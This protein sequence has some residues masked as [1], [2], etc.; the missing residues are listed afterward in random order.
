M[1]FVIKS[2]LIDTI[3]ETYALNQGPM[4]HLQVFFRKVHTYYHLS[5]TVMDIPP[6]EV[7]SDTASDEEVEDEHGEDSSAG[8]KE[9]P[10]PPLTIGAVLRELPKIKSGKET[11]HS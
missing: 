10:P 9:T 8:N 1:K 5:S 2:I 7:L 3:E 6:I 11:S 4:K